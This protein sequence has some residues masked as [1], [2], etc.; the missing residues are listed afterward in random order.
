MRRIDG[1]FAV[2]SRIVMTAGNVERALLDDGIQLGLSGNQT[3]RATGPTGIGCGNHVPSVFEF[4]RRRGNLRRCHMTSRMTMTGIRKAKGKSTTLIEQTR[5]VSSNEIQ[6]IFHP[7]GKGHGAPHARHLQLITPRN[8]QGRKVC[9]KHLP[10]GKRSQGKSR[11]QARRE[12]ARKNYRAGLGIDHLK[13]R[14]CDRHLA[15]CPQKV[16]HLG[17]FGHLD[18]IAPVIDVNRRTTTLRRQG[19]LVGSGCLRLPVDG[20]QLHCC[21]LHNR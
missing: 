9:Q 15:R 18:Q 1:V 17:L 10:V 7:D 5:G 3:R 2:V 12:I 11:V 6:G 16:P 8:I 19:R 13:C 21:P 4:Y 14:G 20:L